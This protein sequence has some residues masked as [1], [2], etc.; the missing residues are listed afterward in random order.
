LIIGGL[1]MKE[2]SIFEKLIGPNRIE[3]TLEFSD[4]PTKETYEFLR[5]YAELRIKA[6]QKPDGMRNMGMAHSYQD[7]LADPKYIKK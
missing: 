3:V 1:G 4:D 5:E 6:L 2:E 7:M